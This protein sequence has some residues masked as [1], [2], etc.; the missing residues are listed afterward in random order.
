MEANFKFIVNYGI[1]ISTKI[2]AVSQNEAPKRLRLDCGLCAGRGGE[3]ARHV[4][5]VVSE[6]GRGVRGVESR[7]LLL[8]N[9]TNAL[10]ERRP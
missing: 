5:G 8:R 3:K 7:T 6:R 10:E 1:V 2:E 4:R 9:E